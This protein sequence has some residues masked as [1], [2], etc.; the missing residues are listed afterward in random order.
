MKKLLIILIIF[1]G[2][3][4][5]ISYLQPEKITFPG[6][7]SYWNETTNIPDSVTWTITKEHLTGAK[8]PRSNKFHSSD[9]RQDLKRDYA[10]SGYDQGHNSPYDDNYYSP[11]AEFQCFDYLN[12]F[13]QL[14]VLNAQTWERLEDFSRKMALQF[15]SCK[16]KTSWAVI[17]RKIGVDSVVVPLYCIKEIWYNG[18]YEKY[19]MPNRDSVIKHPF[20]YYKVK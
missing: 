19:I 11:D 12:M 5:F 13:P 2:I 6:Y 14:H 15:D 18:H 4:S 1:S 17:D 16:V 3:C 20:G 7:T 8:I 10:H 9:S